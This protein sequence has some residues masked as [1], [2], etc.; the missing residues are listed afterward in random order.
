[1]RTQT[2]SF[3][4][5]CFLGDLYIPF[6]LYFLPFFSYDPLIP[7]HETLVV[8]RPGIKPGP[9]ALGAW[10]LSHWTTGEVPVCF[11]L[12]APS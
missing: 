2:T 8:P 1:M 7:T 6:S 9:P 4:D 11:E 3:Q 12:T 5:H 10:S